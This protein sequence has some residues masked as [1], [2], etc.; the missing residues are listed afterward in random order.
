MKKRLGIVSV[1]AAAAVAPVSQ[2]DEFETVITMGHSLC[3]Q[4]P[5]VI[6]CGGPGVGPDGTGMSNQDMEAE[7]ML[8]MLVSLAGPETKKLAD[9]FPPPCIKPGES[10]ADYNAR[11][12]E[13]CKAWVLDTLGAPTNK[14]TTVQVAAK[15]GCQ[16]NSPKFIEYYATGGAM[17]PTS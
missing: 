8:T 12:V 5:F 16:T 11:A 6:E 9:G 3:T 17:C 14:S 15:A 4:Y 13:E 2:A 10:Q 1:V 7:R